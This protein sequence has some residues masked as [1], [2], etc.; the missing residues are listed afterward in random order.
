MIM[1]Q[2]FCTT[3]LL[4]FALLGFAQVRI[5]SHNDY[6]QGKPFHTAYLNKVEEMEADIFLVGDSIIVAHGKKDIEP[7]NTL[8][9][10]YLKPINEK[11]KQYRGQVSEDKDYTFSLMI[12]VKEN[13]ATVYPT[14]KKEIEKYGRIFERNK[15][16]NA[17]RIVISGNRP[18][19]S[20]FRTYP[21]WLFFDGL[22]QLKYAKEDLK[23]V[24]L[25]SDNFASY[26]KW[27][28]YGEIPLADKEKL[29]KLI[30]DAHRINKPIR[31]WAAPDTIDSWEQLYKLGVDMINT[32]KISECSTYFEKHK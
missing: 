26:S 11:F 30:N 16:K 7:S 4:L 12:D 24:A 10:L 9:N 1:K 25:I 13:W 6:S 27:N 22:P 8:Y 17:I 3:L 21:K 23:R 14:L 19:D 31:F 18:T 15:Y 20:T 28:G 5:H 2:F 32:D 29:Q